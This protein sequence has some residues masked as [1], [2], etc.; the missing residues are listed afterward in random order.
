MKLRHGPK[1]ETLLFTK[2]ILQR[3][4]VKNLL[5]CGRILELPPSLNHPMEFLGYSRFARAIPV[6]HVTRIHVE[7]RHTTREQMAVNRNPCVAGS[8]P[9]RSDYRTN[10]EDRVF[11]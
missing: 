9:L 7:Y 11:R 4:D 3:V 6:V 2:H 10:A 1:Y 8:A 5:T